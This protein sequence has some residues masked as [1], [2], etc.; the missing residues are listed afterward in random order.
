MSE[1]A[2]MLPPE[3]YDRRNIPAVI[4][5]GGFGR[6]A[7]R[8]RIM[9]V[10]QVFT[11]VESA[12]FDYCDKNQFIRTRVPNIVSTIGACENWQT[13]FKVDHHTS[14]FHLLTQ[15]G[16]LFLEGALTKH[17]RVCCATKSFRK[18]E[19]EDERHI[20]EF[21]LLE[22]EGAFEFE[23]L[24]EH[25]RGIYRRIAQGVWQSYSADQF[26]DLDVNPEF[27]RSQIAAEIPAIEYTEVIR[28]FPD[29]LTWGDDLT[30]QQEQLAV[31]QVTN[32]ESPILVTHFPRA[33]KFFNM[34]EVRE[35]PT[36]VYSVDLILPISGESAGGALRESDGKRLRERLLESDMYRHHISAGGSY[37]DFKPYMDLIVE[38]RSPV[39][40][41]CGIGAERVI[42]GL[43]QA[44]DIRLCSLDYMN[45]LLFAWDALK[46]P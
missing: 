16:Q 40:S 31:Q 24:L 19:M 32:G 4:R 3:D 43:L 15:T 5:D 21:H 28:M 13:L 14:F 45:K 2:D 22:I 20:T 17:D 36:I 11:A 38:G 27:V 10:N 29:D 18:E 42:Q 39:H 1:F 41:G 8:S 35:N 26:A 46:L 34:A 12:F 9:E 23:E 33:I 44:E 6:E 30:P 37:D 25:M 7:L